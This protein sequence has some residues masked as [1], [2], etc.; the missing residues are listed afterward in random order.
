[1]DPHKSA[2]LHGVRRITAD[3]EQPGYEAGKAIDGDVQTL[4]RTSWEREAPGFPHELTIEL[5]ACGVPS[6]KRP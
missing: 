1:M 4:W 5:D 2:G 6:Q 3:S